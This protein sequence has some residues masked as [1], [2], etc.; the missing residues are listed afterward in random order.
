MS[1]LSIERSK[2]SNSIDT[3]LRNRKSEYS[4]THVTNTSLISNFDKASTRKK[5]IGQLHDE[6]RCKNPKQSISKSNLKTLKDEITWILLDILH[7]LLQIYLLPFPSLL[8]AQRGSSLCIVSVSM[9]RLPVA[10]GQWEASA[11]HL[12]PERQA[13]I[14]CL[15]PWLLLSFW[16]VVVSDCIYVPQTIS[17]V[18][19]SALVHYSS[20]W[21]LS[22]SLSFYSFSLWVLL[23]FVVRFKVLQ[24][25]I[26]ISFDFINNLFLNTSQINQF[27]C[28]C[29]TLTRTV[30]GTRDDPR[31]QTLKWNPG[32][33]CSH[34]WRTYG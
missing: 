29:W 26:L 11:G 7:L 1:Q 3:L 13:E 32:F 24:F 30:I 14:G 34:I 21:I 4:P 15:F 16:S 8:C 31:K 12:R 20:L 18:G 6:D 22:F 27:K 28:T 2:V 9:W 23:S 17:L 5:L 10:F 25:F 19:W 33:G